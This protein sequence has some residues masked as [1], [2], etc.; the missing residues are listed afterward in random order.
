MENII[1]KNNDILELYFINK[2]YIFKI[3][4]YMLKEII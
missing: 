3:N 2:L 1:N 4:Y